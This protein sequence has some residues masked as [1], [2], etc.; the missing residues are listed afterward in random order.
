MDRQKDRLKDRLKDRGQTERQNDF[1]ANK[2][3]SGCQK[4]RKTG[5]QTKQIEGQKDIRA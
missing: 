1:S 4:D 2:S 3:C 5:R